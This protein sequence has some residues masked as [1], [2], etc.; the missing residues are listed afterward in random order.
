[1]FT[2]IVNA[3]AFGAQ[4]GERA[5]KLS[6]HAAMRMYS[7]NMSNSLNDSSGCT[8]L[9]V[10]YVVIIWQLSRSAVLIQLSGSSC[11][12]TTTRRLGSHHL[13][14][15]SISCPDTAV[16]QQLAVMSRM[17]SE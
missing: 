4:T 3:L 17:L 16:R 6:I 11:H 10:V 14:A 5:K 7:T 1:M 15:V 13:A 2:I 8:R 12:V 9:L